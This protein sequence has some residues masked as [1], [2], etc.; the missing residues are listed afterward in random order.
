M[1]VINPLLKEKLEK[2]LIKADEND[3]LL[4]SQLQYRKEMAESFEELTNPL[5]QEE[6]RL[7]KKRNGLVR[8][9]TAKVG[10]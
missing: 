7:K 9:N 1:V 3:I 5:K 2:D 6:R 4:P 10:L 8:K